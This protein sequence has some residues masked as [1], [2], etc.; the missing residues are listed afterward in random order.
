MSFGAE[1]MECVCAGWD[2]SDK[3]LKPE[4]DVGAGQKRKANFENYNFI[5]RRTRRYFG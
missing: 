1:M 2:R 4:T 5:Q 3:R